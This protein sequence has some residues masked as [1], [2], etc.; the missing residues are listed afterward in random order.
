MKS[1][2]EPLFLEQRTYRRR[3]MADAVR[4]LPVFG[5]ILVSVPLLWG[6]GPASAALTTGVML[7]LFVVWGLLVGLSAVI[8]RKLREE[9]TRSADN[10][11]PSKPGV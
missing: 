3:R 10:E 7:Y 9:E 1:K 8:S 6:Q 5:A 11:T 2:A 4:I